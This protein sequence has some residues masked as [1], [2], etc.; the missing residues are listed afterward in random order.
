MVPKLFWHNYQI[1]LYG[2]KKNNEEEL[3]LLGTRTLKEMNGNDMALIE[4]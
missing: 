3:S 1:V 2:G 4:K